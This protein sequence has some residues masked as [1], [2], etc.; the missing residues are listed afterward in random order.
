MKKIN[1]TKELGE[2]IRKVRK[3]QSLTQEHLA[4]TCGVGI[5]FIREL[6]QGK[7]SCHIG[8]AFLVIL[9]LGIEV[10]LERHSL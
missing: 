4:A 1:N 7:K 5:R 2:T 8:K 9:M 10:K 3:S 6:E